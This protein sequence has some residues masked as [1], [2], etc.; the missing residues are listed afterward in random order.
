LEREPETVAFALDKLVLRLELDTTQGKIGVEGLVG[1]E[2]ARDQKTLGETVFDFKVVALT[3]E[4]ALFLLLGGTALALFLGVL[5]LGF[6]EAVM[7]RAAIFELDLA[8]LDPRFLDF[9]FG[10][11]ARV[12]RL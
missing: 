3:E 1:R 5:A 6:W 12:A 10:E 8:L 9:E 11:G 4:F 2:R 7:D